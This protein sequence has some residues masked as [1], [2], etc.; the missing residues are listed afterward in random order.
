MKNDA[1]VQGHKGGLTFIEVVTEI[2]GAF[3][4]IISPF[5]LGA[6][7]GFIVY[8][9]FPGIVGLIVGLL[10]VLLGLAL[11]IFWAIRIWRRKGTIN[12]LSRILATPE[13]YPEEQNK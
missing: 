12:Y 2:I 13:L 7:L 10:I 3:Q 1:K 6:I 8:L 9:A 5:A 4:I 11:G